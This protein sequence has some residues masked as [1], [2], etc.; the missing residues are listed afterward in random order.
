MKTIFDKTTT[1]ELIR[2]INSLN[3]N[4]TAQ[5]GKMTV[6]QM[7]KHCRM[8]EEM[9]SGKIQCKRIFL[10]RLIGSIA[11]KHELKDETPMGRNS[12]TSV[13]L[14]VTE[15]NIDLESERA[16]WIALIEAHEHFSNPNFVHPFFGEMTKEQ[17]G[18]FAYKHT[19]HHLRQFNC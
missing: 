14:K 2:R 15:S 18:Y 4:S 9:L 12:P 8:W 13:E 11:L 17:I 5:W 7:M 10:G 1:D 6:Y 3:E 16:K 19:D